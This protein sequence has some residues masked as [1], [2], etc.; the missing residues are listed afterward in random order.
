MR[1][2]YAELEVSQRLTEETNTLIH[3][4]KAGLTAIVP[5]PRRTARIYDWKSFRSY[6]PTIDTLTRGLAVFNSEPESGLDPEL[7]DAKAVLYRATALMKRAAIAALWCH[8][9]TEAGRFSRAMDNF[10]DF[11][12]SMRI[13]GP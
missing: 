10:K 6:Q 3:E 11:T 2:G 12:C 9:N 4:V 7:R 1:F 8:R 13:A 5:V